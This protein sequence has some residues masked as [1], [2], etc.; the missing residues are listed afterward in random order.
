MADAD[1]GRGLVLLGM[2]ASRVSSNPASNGP[3]PLLALVFSGFPHRANRVRQPAAARRCAVHV[4][5]A[6]QTLLWSEAQRVFESRCVVCHGCY[7]AP[8]QLK[9]GTFDGVARGASQRQDLRWR[10]PRRGDADAPRHRRARRE[11]MAKEGLP[12]ACCPRATRPIRAPASCCSM[13]DLKRAHPL[14]F[15]ADLSR[16]FT[17][18]LDRMETCA[19][20]EH[21][22]D[23]AKSHPLWGMPYALP[24]L[25]PAQDARSDRLGLARAL[26]SPA[27]VLPAP[28][29]R[30]RSQTGRP[31]STS[32]RP[33]DSSSDGYI[34]EHLF[35]A[36]LYFKGLADETFFR[37]VRS[38]TPS[39]AAGR[40]DSDAAPLRRSRVRAR[41]LPLRS[42]A[43]SARSRRRTCPI[44]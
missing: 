34:Y 26:R 39:G 37:L 38:R 14:P 13:L 6:G 18:E 21:F 4:D 30:G 12:P 3:S 8:C 40:R 10:A 9:L 42:S 27:A 15:T 33:G 41:L 44:R 19:T 35:L 1:R 28:R 24:G 29:E 2:L 23:Y 5:A 16:D 32:P 7:D 25:D 31:S 22:E 20:A 17:L 43:R 11:R 36:S